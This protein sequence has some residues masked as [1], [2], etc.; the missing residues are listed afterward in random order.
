[1]PCNILS[2]STHTFNKKYIGKTGQG[3]TK[4]RDLSIY[5]V[6]INFVYFV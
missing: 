3:I 1:M 6:M 2:F 4:S 5:V